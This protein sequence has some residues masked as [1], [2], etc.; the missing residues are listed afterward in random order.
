MTYFTVTYAINI[1][2][3]CSKGAVG[4][5]KAS[6]LLESPETLIVEKADLDHHSVLQTL[7]SDNV[8]LFEKNEWVFFSS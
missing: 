2:F 4:A 3:Y 8:N 1:L 5:A 7:R 6:I